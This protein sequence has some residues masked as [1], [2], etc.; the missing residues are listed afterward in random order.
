MDFS[1]YKYLQQIVGYEPFCSRNVLN[2]FN[3]IYRNTTSVIIL[4]TQS[5]WI[6]GCACQISLLGITY[7][8][9]YWGFKVGPMT[10]FSD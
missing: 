6:Y 5:S 10:G 9:F 7:E 4:G 3:F 8:G 2:V 1:S